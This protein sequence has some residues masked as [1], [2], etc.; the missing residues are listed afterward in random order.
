LKIITSKP[1]V[2]WNAKTF[3]GE[4]VLWV[5]PQNSIYFVDIKKKKIFIMNIKNRKK[6]IIKLDK[7]IGF[8]AHIKKK[9]FILGLKSELRLIDLKSKKTLRSIKIEK[10]KPLNRIND[11]KVDYK[12]R[13][14][15]GTMDNLERNI[16]NGSL[17]CL[18][19]K[20]KIHKVDSDYIITNG[21]T[22]IDNDKFYHTDSRKKIIY[23]IKI[24]TKLK[25]I[26]KN[27]FLKF[28]KKNG[29]PDGMTMDK[30]NNLWVCHYGG[31]CISVYNPRG[32]RI[33]T[34]NLP[35][36]NITNCTFAGKNNKDLYITT[37]IKGLS[38]SEIIKYPLSGSLFKVITNCSGKKSKSFNI[39]K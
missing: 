7:E 18:D 27:K 17:Y 10:E 33:H 6:K 20:L 16:N 8:L 19:K 25:I 34:V 21:P 12:N 28:N 11:G 5:K 26:K 1:E 31:S 32:K 24:N 22:F 4:G 3:L 36:K 14:W 29:S 39:Q 23:K 37:A 15:F 9:I 13:L 2:I 30:K 35:V 38:K